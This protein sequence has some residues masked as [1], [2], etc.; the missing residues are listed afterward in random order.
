[1]K[2]ATIFTSPPPQ[3]IL[4]PGGELSAGDGGESAVWVR[5]CRVLWLPVPCQGPLYTP[6]CFRL[7]LLIVQKNPGRVKAAAVLRSRHLRL[8][9]FIL[10]TILASSA[11]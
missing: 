8:E 6:P 1:M 3:P 5:G 11:S 4:N 10:V 9:R 2:V 7:E